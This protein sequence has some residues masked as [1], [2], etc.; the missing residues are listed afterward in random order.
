MD[1]ENANSR[2]VKSRS[3]ITAQVVAHIVLIIF[4]VAS[5]V[6]FILLV[7]SSFTQEQELIA[8][9]YTFF[10]KHWS[11]ES[12][13]YI[14]KTNAKNIFRAYGI[15]MI[16]TLVGTVLGLLLTSLMGYV[17]SRE[18]YPRRKLLNFLVF[19]TMLFNGGL[20]PTYISY[21]RIFHIKD[22]WF[23]YLIPA[24]LMNAFNV[25]LM[26]SY[27]K[28]NIHP[29]LIEAAKVDGASETTIFFR[30]ILP[31]SLPIEATIGLMVGLN[32]WNDWM[33]PLYY[34]TKQKLWS[35]Q[36]LLNRILTSIQTLSAMADKI[37]GVTAQLPST[38]ARMAI[39]VIGV[40][41]IMALYPFFQKYFV[42]GIALGGV[43]E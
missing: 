5:I 13:A 27:F 39:A 21:T 7:V 29:S 3:D 37:G 19:F 8:S 25:M 38:G 9:G 16:N 32:Y 6:P 24:L 12:Y 36:S 18:K 23:A 33:N 26:K 10:P 2:H 14:F 11:L 42:K 35:L 15:T 31:L 1:E 28:M 22:T 40:V 43:K 41:P 17:I 4:S 34:I 20:V 30:I